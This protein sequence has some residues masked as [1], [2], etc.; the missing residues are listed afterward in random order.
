MRFGTV[1][2]LSGLCRRDGRLHGVAPV[3]WGTHA[4]F[5]LVHRVARGDPAPLR[6]LKRTF[7]S[8]RAVDGGKYS[9]FPVW[10]EVGKMEKDE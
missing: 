10:A 1:C 3:N 4:D 9:T 8:R 5:V 2:R 7:R 6:S